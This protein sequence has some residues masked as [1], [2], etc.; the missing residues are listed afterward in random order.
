[1]LSAVRCSLSTAILKETSRG[2]SQLSAKVRHFMIF[3]LIIL[4]VV[5]HQKKKLLQFVKL[6]QCQVKILLVF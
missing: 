2:F 3:D 5:F 6:Q 1:M 4:N